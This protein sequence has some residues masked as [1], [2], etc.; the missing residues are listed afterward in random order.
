MNITH[1]MLS[2]KK[3]LDEYWDEV[4][5]CSIYLLNK[6]PM[7]SVQDNIP[8]ESCSGT[9]SSVAHLRFFGS[10]S[11]SQVLGELRRKMDKKS[12][13]FLFTWYNEPHK[14]YKLYNIGTKRIVVGKYVELLEDKCSSDPSYRQEK[15]I[16]DLS[17]IP[18][19]IPILEV[20]QQ[21][22]TGTHSPS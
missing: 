3:L 12:E 21:E 2:H 13:Q 11:F 16:L 5:G 15:E 10:I 1:S 14:D 19:R 7:V 8:E 9:K 20:Q 17:D 4:V 18:I 6:S 22:E